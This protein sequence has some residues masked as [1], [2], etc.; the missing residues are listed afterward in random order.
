MKSTEEYRALAKECLRE[1]E[2]VPEGMRLSYIMIAQLWL[3]FADKVAQMRLEVAAN[4]RL[5]QRVTVE[6]T[7]T[8]SFLPL[9]ARGPLSLPREQPFANLCR[10]MLKC[11]SSAPP[12][13]ESER[14]AA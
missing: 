2:I 12:G 1:A 3:E 8:S 5:V 11:S 6:L 7:P 4:T 13:S 10:S 9:W 14:P